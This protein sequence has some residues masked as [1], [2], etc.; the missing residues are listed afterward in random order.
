MTGLAFTW[1][2]TNP[3]VATIHPTT[4]VAHGVSVGTTTIGATGCTVTAVA[5]LSV[6]A[7]PPVL[8]G[9]SA[10]PA[11]A[12]V[13]TG[14]S[15]PL[16]ATATDAAGNAVSGIAFGWSSSN[17]AVAVVSEIGLVT[18]VSPGAAQITATAGGRSGSMTVTVVAASYVITGKVTTSDGIPLAGA[19]VLISALSMSATTDA[20]GVFRL[21]GVPPGTYTVLA[22]ALHYQ[23]VT[24]DVSVTGNVSVSFMLSKPPA[25][26]PG[27][28]VGGLEG[29]AG[30]GN[31][32]LI[33][34]GLLGLL[35]P[36]RRRR[37]HPWFT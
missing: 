19:T 36:R 32:L 16:R 30:Y 11:Q 37:H 3:A 13:A 34:I 8:G 15:V 31:L 24:Q 27:C 6:S 1:V 2:S 14:G 28:S 18:G 17:P 7:Q 35:I 22:T 23:G 4:G 29:R 9:V 5:V 25:E 26:T 10:S 21:A 20:T 12:T 33:G